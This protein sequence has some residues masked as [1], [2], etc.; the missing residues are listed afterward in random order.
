MISLIF[1]LLAGLMNGLIDKVGDDY[2]HSWLAIF[3]NPR[4]FD[5]NVSFVNKYS[6]GDEIL[7]DPRTVRIRK[8]LFWN[9]NAPVFYTDFWHFGKSVMLWCLAIAAG[10]HLPGLYFLPG[11]VC[12]V[13]ARCAFGLGFL[14]T[15]NT[16]PKTKT[17]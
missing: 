2:T 4:W 3:G 1:L 8:K 5:R 17:Q 6:N 7:K 10:L 12:V 15:Y 9:I 13:L 14:L 16:N 11:W